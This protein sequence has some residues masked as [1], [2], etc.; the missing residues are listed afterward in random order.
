[1]ADLPPPPDLTPF[2]EGERARIDARL[3]DGKWRVVYPPDLAERGLALNTTFHGLTPLSRLDLPDGRVQ[4]TYR[5]P[6]P[7]GKGPDGP[8]LS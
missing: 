7:T 8:L 4:I 3:V 1:M 5:L 2:T 6:G